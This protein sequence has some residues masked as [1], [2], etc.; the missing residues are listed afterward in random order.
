MGAVEETRIV[1]ATTRHPLVAAYAA[2][3]ASSQETL[4]AE[5]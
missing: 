1:W 4:R 3:F 2:A 5:R